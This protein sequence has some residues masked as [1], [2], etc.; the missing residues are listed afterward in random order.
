MTLIWGRPPSALVVRQ[1]L[2]HAGRDRP[3]REIRCRGASSSLVPLGLACTHSPMKPRGPPTGTAATRASRLGARS[4]PCA[5]PTRGMTPPGSVSS[6][7]TQVAAN[8]AHVLGPKQWTMGYAPQRSPAP[9]CLTDRPWDPTEQRTPHDATGVLPSSL[10]HHVRV[11]VRTLET[12]GFGVV[13]EPRHAAR[14]VCTQSGGRL[15]GSRR[16]VGVDRNFDI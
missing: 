6:I 1:R 12:S 13:S 8:A 16:D 3:E 5:I 15:G 7:S 10:K 2:S 4:P 14:P 11:A 9:P